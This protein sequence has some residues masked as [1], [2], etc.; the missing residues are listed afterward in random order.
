MSLIATDIAR[1]PML[2]RLSLTLEPGTV[3]GL[4]G[5]NGAGKTTLLRALGGLGGG[6]GSGGGTLR[7]AGEA[8]ESLSPRARVRRL[9]WL[10]AD[11]DIAWPMR[12]DDLVQ[13]GLGPGAGHDAAA[14]AA[15]LQATDAG[16]FA[17][18][19]VDTLSTGERA[20]VLLARAIVA[21]PD[22]LLLDEPVANLD[23]GHRIDV[24]ALLR[25]EAGRGAGV[26]VALHDLDLARRGCDRLL[27]LDKGVAVADGSPA[28]VLTAGRLRAVFGI[29]ASGDGWEK[30]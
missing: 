21:R 17:G 8:L 7:V 2:A 14:V 28:S 25:A 1:A 29:R 26:V 5:P 30:A 19:R 10:P 13:L 12:A 6:P 11:R 20:R 27:L 16:Q 18:R 15:A 4:I 23:P 9:A 24:M 22:W 3:T